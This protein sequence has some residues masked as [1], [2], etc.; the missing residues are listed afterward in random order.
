MVGEAVGVF[1]RSEDLQGAIDEL[2]Q[3]GFHRAALSLVASEQTIDQKLSYRYRKVRP[4]ED[5][6]LT[7]APRTRCLKRSATP[8]AG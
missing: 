8:R 3:S 7:R 2:L 1:H 6:P 5:D 4:L